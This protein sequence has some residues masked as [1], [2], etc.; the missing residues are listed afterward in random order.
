MRMKHIP[1]YEYN[2]LGEKAKEVVKQWYL[3]DPSRATMLTEDFQ[4]MFL[5]YF[6]P[7]SNLKVQ[8]SLSSCQGDGVN[9]YGDLQLIEII[10]YIKNWNPEEHTYKYAYSPTEVFTEAE[11]KTIEG[12]VKNEHTSVAITTIPENRRYCYCT[13]SSIELVE[14]LIEDLEFYDVENIDRD[15]IR[16][17]EQEVISIIGNMCA[18]MQSYGY[19][20]L[21]DCEEEELKETCDINKWYF[22]AD[23][24]YITLD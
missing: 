1:C 4:N 15:L 20:Y 6:F 14:D 16:C 18:E 12:Y 19:N 22:E 10:N 7:N 3:N 13:S 24:K 8:W 5:N 11:L 2:E 23:G 17:F 9:I 21:N